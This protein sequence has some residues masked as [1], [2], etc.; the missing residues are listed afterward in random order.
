MLSTLLLSVLLTLQKVCV[1][2]FFSMFS[3][4]FC[5]LI[6]EKTDSIIG[7]T[8]DGSEIPNHHL[9]WLNPINNG[10][11]QDFVQQHP[12]TV[13][14]ILK[15]LP[16]DKLPAE[17]RLGNL[18][19]WQSSEPELLR[20]NMPNLPPK[21]FIT[22][23]PSMGLVYLP[24]HLPAKSTIHVGINISYLD[25]MDNT[26][27][28]HDHLRKTN[29]C[30]TTNLNPLCAVTLQFTWVAWLGSSSAKVDQHIS[31]ISSKSTTSGWFQRIWK[32]SVKVGSWPQ[33]GLKINKYLKPPPSTISRWMS[34]PIFSNAVPHWPLCHIP[35]IG[36]HLRDP[37]DR[38]VG[39]LC[40]LAFELIYKLFW[41]FVFIIS[42]EMV[43]ILWLRPI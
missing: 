22:H 18:Q 7:H 5:C 30:T 32:I 12:S 26:S 11:V 25:P 43:F 31:I 39:K 42:H 9:G 14:G 20:T 8:V 40:S 10:M 35:L 27:R 28:N 13:V 23:G 36:Q 24:I 4:T 41:I 34:P 19:V 3:A 17:C 33:V 1:C 38:F 15:N 21:Y 2:V 29:P 6:S 37:A 16:V